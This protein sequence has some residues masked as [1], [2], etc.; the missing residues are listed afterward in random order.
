MASSIA[1]VLHACGATL[2]A[3]EQLD[4]V[5]PY[6]D[7]QCEAKHPNRARARRL[8]G[9]ILAHTGDVESAE[10]VLREA[11]ALDLDWRG[12]ESR[13][14]ALSRLALGRFLAGTNRGSE[15]RAELA[16]ARRI[17][18]TAPF[19][20]GRWLPRVDEALQALDVSP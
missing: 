12:P 6:Y 7:R 8:L 11:L 19:H 13:A 15:A 9:A 18:Q 4:I 2:D 1:E 3:R 14:T 5:L 20:E 17:L 10:T 16:D